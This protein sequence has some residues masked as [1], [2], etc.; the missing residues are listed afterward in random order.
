MLTATET[1]TATLEPR[2]PGSDAE[3]RAA[4]AL[5]AQLRRKPKAEIETFWCRPNWAL[6][7]AVNLVPALVGSLIAVNHAKA[8][9]VVILVSLLLLV[10]DWVLGISPGRFAGFERASQN[11]VAAAPQN[12][13][14]TATQ[15]AP[16]TLILTASYDSPRTGLATTL[17]ARG[18]TRAPQ[19]LLRGGAPG[20][21][22]WLA[23]LVGWTLVTALVRVNGSHDVVIG[24]AQLIPTVALV[25]AVAA[26]LELSI[27]TYRP[28]TNDPDSAA[29]A[30]IALA[31]A[32]DVA[33]PA[34]LAVEVVLTGVGANQG[35][36]LRA[37]LRSRRKRLKRTNTVVLGVE[38][39]D[40]PPRALLS[41]G[42]LIP[43]RFFGP[44]QKL[45]A[46]TGFQPARG[47]GCSAAF[48]ARM[49]RLP[50]LTITG[51][52]RDLLPLTL[53]LVDAIDVY[54]GDLHPD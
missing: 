15:T 29:Q 12:V 7:Q 13:V 34:N 51:R 6:A 50:A 18:L 19:R 2:P 23:L 42:P 14:A 16:V 33:S 25:L 38:A 21:L 40:G 26:L 43:L 28:T 11:V 52:H 35:L 44:L 54:V 31:K 20:W 53:E 47:R 37:Y 48:P 39:S 1:P 8:G 27:S 30:V 17:R 36:G 24:V 22:A 10:G 3:R 41:D 4:H 32:L 46:E 49:K 5:G 9:A 45:A